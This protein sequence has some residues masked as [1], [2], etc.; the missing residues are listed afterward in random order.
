MECP[1]QSYGVFDDDG[2][3]HGFLA[4]TLSTSEK[5]DDF[6]AMELRVFEAA[7]A[8][9]L[10]GL[11][12]LLRS[13]HS[14]VR[15]LNTTLPPQNPFWSYL[16]EQR[17]RMRI[18]EQFLI[19]LV[20]IGDALNQRG[21][22]RALEGE[23]LLEIDDPVLP[24]NAGLWHL[25]VRD[26]RG[27]ATKIANPDRASGERVRLDAGALA[28]LYSGHQPAENLAMLGRAEGRPEALAMASA[29]FIGRAVSCPE[30]F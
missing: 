27:S 5:L 18:R 28:A 30:M 19:R 4:F 24:A 29:L 26:G 10:Q 1:S 23:I 14:M 13:H 20:R 11:M 8:E 6:Q 9:G 17:A 21:Y 12:A 3:L 16:P 15:V 25:R 22:P 2:Q 7:D